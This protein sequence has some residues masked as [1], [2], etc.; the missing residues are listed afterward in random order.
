MQG[1]SGF[2]RNFL[3]LNKGEIMLHL[4]GGVVIYCR[5]WN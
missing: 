5:G 4:A 2:E 1:V 3:R